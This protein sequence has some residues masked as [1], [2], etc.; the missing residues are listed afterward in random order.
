MRND[1]KKLA[2]LV[3]LQRQVEQMHAARQT[4][5][6]SEQLSAQ[7]EA[8]DLI[9]RADK[10]G[11]TAQ[12]FPSLYY[13][14]IN[15]CSARSAQKAE[16]AALEADHRTMARRRAEKLNEKLVAAKRNDERK[17]EERDNLERIQATSGTQS[18]RFKQV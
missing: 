18:A 10:D 9:E 14:R 3:K 1:P 13:R 4:L 15:E 2:R 7:K 17:R 11:A 5:L 12:L 16:A 8:V 6:L